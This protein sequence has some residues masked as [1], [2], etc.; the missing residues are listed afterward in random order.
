VEA[1]AFR[2]VAACLPLSILC[3]S[4][5]LEVS[6]TSPSH[7]MM[8]VISTFVPLRY[9]R[10][11]PL[12]D[13]YLITLFVCMTASPLPVGFKL[14]PSSPTAKS[15]LLISRHTPIVLKLCL[16]SSITP[17]TVLFHSLFHSSTLPLAPTLLASYSIE[18]SSDKLQGT[19]TSTRLDTGR[20]LRVGQLRG[21]RHRL[22]VD[23]DSSPR[24]PQKTKPYVTSPTLSSSLLL[25]LFPSLSR[26]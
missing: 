1:L 2:L 20:R 17:I 19:L 15:F 3:E 26:V 9:I 24:L 4:W 25:I 21:S 7:I 18:H 16:P 5:L 10:F 6:S 12:S 22:R 14:P 23:L 13:A 8:L 11:Y